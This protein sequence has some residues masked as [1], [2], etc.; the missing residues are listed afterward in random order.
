MTLQTSLIGCVI[1][2]CLDFLTEAYE[3]SSLVAAEAENHH[4]SSPEEHCLPYRAVLLFH[5]A[6]TKSKPAKAKSIHRHSGA[7]RLR[8]NA[9]TDLAQTTTLGASRGSETGSARMTAR[10]TATRSGDGNSDSSL[11][12][13]KPPA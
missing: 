5:T 1:R 8:T 11:L 12:N 7:C 13:K 2:C 10:R 3:C 9:M 4:G 6:I